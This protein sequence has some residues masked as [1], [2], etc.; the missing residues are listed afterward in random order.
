MNQGMYPLAAA[1]VNQI[2]RVDTVSNNLANSRTIGFKQENLAEGTF[3]NYLLKANLEGKKPEYINELTNK[4]PKIDQ[5]FIDS[6]QGPIVQTGNNL[7]FALKEPQTFF[8]VLDQNGNVQYTKDGSFKNS[9]GFLV[10]SNGN[11]VLS[12]DGEP[13]AIEDGFKQAIGVFNIDYKNLEKFGDNNYKLK[14]EQQVAVQVQAEENNEN[15]IL[16]GSLE[17]SNVN[18]VMAMVQLI[19]AQRSY[20]Q[21]QK[22]ITGIDSMNKTIIQKLGNG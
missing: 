8:A 10:D 22:G 4:V 20:E 12:G 9:D 15:F 13:I 6:S 11:N 18:S 16:Q 1:M 5:K 2:N 14:D 3:N 19:E 21:A 17:Q 7:D